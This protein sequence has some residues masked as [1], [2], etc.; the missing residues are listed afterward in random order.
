[1]GNLYIR[2]YAAADHGMG[3]EPAVAMQTL[4]L[5]DGAVSEKFNARTR[6]VSLY[7]DAPCAVAFGPSPEATDKDAHLARDSTTMF[8]VQP[9]HKVAVIAVNT[10]HDE[11]PTESVFSLLSLVADPTKTKARLEE[12][13][14]LNA[15]VTETLANVKAQ[16]AETARVNEELT[17][18]QKELEGREAAVKTAEQMAARNA[19]EYKAR[20]V[21]HEQAV[22]AHGD[23]VVEHK[24]TSDAMQAELTK[25]Q[26]AL[27]KH[28]MDVEAALVARVSAA[29]QREAHLQAEEAR[30]TKMDADY[31]AKLA[32]FK[33][34][35]A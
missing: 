4:E 31:R 16:S 33:E 21:A 28:T 17:K 20:V 24:R 35:A 9:E 7:P 15:Q 2:E 11:S 1:M 26:V 29:A 19:T 8:R 14:K 22:K 25:Q 10:S 30:L 5:G 13:T 3:S 34:L 32:K 12:L 18:R 6:I 23:A 27:E